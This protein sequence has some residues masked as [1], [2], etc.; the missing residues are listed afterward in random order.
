MSNMSEQ[1]DYSISVYGALL[2]SESE[3]D[4]CNCAKHD[5]EK[6]L[7]GSVGRKDSA[8]NP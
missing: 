1:T 7:V 5:I 8:I 2:V 4:Y 3:L 6:S